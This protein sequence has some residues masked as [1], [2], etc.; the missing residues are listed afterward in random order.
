MNDVIHSWVEDAV[1]SH[2]TSFSAVP[3]LFEPTLSIV[4]SS[5]AAFRHSLLEDG[6]DFR[7][8]TLD[9]KL[10]KWYAHVIVYGFDIRMKT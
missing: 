7:I 2:L 1:R 5:Q 3:R 9:Y 8:C 6:V 10:G 4:N